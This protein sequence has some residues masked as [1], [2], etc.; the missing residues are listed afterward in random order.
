MGFQ[1]LTGENHPWVRLILSV[2]RDCEVSNLA[3]CC[4]ICGIMQSTDSG[5]WEGDGLAKTRPSVPS[6]S[7]QPKS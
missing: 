3:L 7:G 5:G 1:Q 4:D 2:C 6:V